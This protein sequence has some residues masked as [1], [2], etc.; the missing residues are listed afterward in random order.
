MDSSNPEFQEL[1]SF[2][3]SRVVREAG[4]FMKY[5][6][7]AAEMVF[8]GASKEEAIDAL[9]PWGCDATQSN[10][11]VAG[12]LQAARLVRLEQ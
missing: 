12:A 7:K 3:A 6:D 1:R 9:A 11:V 4:T 10:G 5:Y 8:G 2:H